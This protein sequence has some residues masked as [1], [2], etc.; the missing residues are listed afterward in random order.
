VTTTTTTVTQM[1]RVYVTP[2]SS[3]TKASKVKPPSL[4]TSH[5][6]GSSSPKSKSKSDLQSSPLVSRLALP[7]PS[8]HG[9]PSSSPRPYP[10]P[11]SQP[12]SP[13]VPRQPLAP[14]AP[15]YTLSPAAGVEVLHPV[16][17]PDEICGPKPSQFIQGYY[18]VFCGRECGIFYTW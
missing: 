2:L 5:G 10:S 15:F 1:H 4:L 11:M 18:V 7:P 9:A 17:H 13:S 16:P 14:N 8:Y 3:P 6:T 12:L